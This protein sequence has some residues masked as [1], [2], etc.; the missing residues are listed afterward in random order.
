MWGLGGGLGGRAVVTLAV[1]LV[2]ALEAVRQAVFV[3]VVASRRQGK[4]NLARPRE[5][6]VR[7]FHQDPPYS[8]GALLT[9]IIVKYIF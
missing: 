4:D 5:A 1:L 3:V 9:F 2:R 6:H 7:Q 8:L